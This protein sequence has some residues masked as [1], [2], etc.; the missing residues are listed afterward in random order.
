MIQK[1]EGIVVNNE[2]DR[3][4]NYNTDNAKLQ[5][6]TAIALKVNRKK[7]SHKK[8][9]SFTD[10]IFH[11]LAIHEI[12]F[13]WKGKKNKLKIMKFFFIIPVQIHIAHP[14]RTMPFFQQHIRFILVYNLKS[15]FFL[16]LFFFLLLRFVIHFQL[17]S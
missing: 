8:W 16:I 1:Y 12:Q 13:C 2:N 7:A 11:I 5:N 3:K 4:H 10:H 14:F 17:M 6:S 9:W 15:F